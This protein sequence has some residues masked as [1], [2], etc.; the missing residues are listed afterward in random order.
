MTSTAAGPAMEGNGLSCGTPAIPGAISDVTLTPVMPRLQTIDNKLP[1]GLCGS[2]A[3]SLF[4]ELIQRGYMTQDG[5]LTES[6]PQDGLL[7]AKQPTGDSLSFSR[8][9][10]RQMQVAIAAIGAGIDTLLQHAGISA[11]DIHHLYL[12]GGLG[13]HI[14]I[15]K[16][17]VTGIFA[18]ID[19]TRISAVGNSCLLGL[20]NL[21]DSLEETRQRIDQ[22]HEKSEEIILAEDVNFQKNFIQHMTY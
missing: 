16:A 9:D 17:A 13:Y 5:I 20:A 3:I 18:G 1:S 22:I 10:V 2:G 7:L 8:E 6:F 19:P 21:P 11:D 14:N 4:S 12:A 15:A